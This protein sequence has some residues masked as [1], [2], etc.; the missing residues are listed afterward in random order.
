[1]NRDYVVTGGRNNGIKFLSDLH[2][3]NEYG[4]GYSNTNKGK[5]IGSIKAEVIYDSFYNNKLARNGTTVTNEADNVLLLVE[6]IGQDNMSDTLANVCRD[7]F[8]EFTIE[9]CIKYGIPTHKK[10]SRFF[11][12][13]T[14]KWEKK[15]VQLPFFNGGH[16]ILVPKFI[17][18][19]KRAYQNR[20][21]WYVSSNYISRDILS[22]KIKIKEDSPYIFKKKDGSS[23][24]L[25]KAINKDFSKPKAKLIE[26]I[27]DYPKSLISFKD[28]AKIYYLCYKE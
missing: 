8:A 23:K 6:G 5:G 2:E 14:K 20:Y 16:I 24:A 13:L 21:N 3:A 10:S 15:I 9:Q 11:N 22:G 25:V 26:H 28:Y 7:V 18:S 1:M 19:G 12:G 4:L 17:S 27:V